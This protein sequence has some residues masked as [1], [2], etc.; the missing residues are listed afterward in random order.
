MSYDTQ[1]DAPFVL[2]RDVAKFLLD[3]NVSDYSSSLFTVPTADA[4]TNASSRDVIGNKTDAAVTTVGT[5]KTIMAHVKGCLSVLVNATYGLSAIKTLIDTL[6]GLHTVPTADATTNT[7]SRDVVGNKT[8]A[9]VYAVAANKSEM[10]YTK[11]ILN[12]LTKATGAGLLVSK[13]ITLNGNGAQT[14]NLFTLTGTVYLKAIWAQITEATESTTCS[15]TAFLLYDSTATV[16]ITKLSSGLDMSGAAV[17]DVFYKGAAS[18]SNAIKL[19]VAAG[20]VNEAGF[21]GIF[22]QKKTGAATYVQVGFTG[23]ANTDIDA[24]FYAVYEPISADG[25]LAAV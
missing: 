17:G 7:N 10:A 12:V 14:D 19:A 1:H 2:I 6:T 18:T 9:A 25:A 8:D 20:A 16:D 3:G 21:D 13:S 24:T 4:T 23:D 22:L 5:T 11:G 15:S